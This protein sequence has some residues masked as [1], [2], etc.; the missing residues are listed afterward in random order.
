[1]TDGIVDPASPAAA[2]IESI[3]H[4]VAAIRTALGLGEDEERRVHAAGRYLAGYVDGWVDAF[5]TRLLGNPTAMLLL[6]DDARVIRLKRSLTAWFHELFSLPYDEHYGRARQAIGTAHV[7]INMPVYLMVTAMGGIRRDV[8]RSIA[9]AYAH[10]PAESEAVGRAVSLVLDLELAL[11]L[12]AFRREERALSRRQD[13]AVYAERAARRFSHLLIDRIN[14][15]ICYAELADR[16]DDRRAERLQKLKDVLQS[17]ARFDHRTQIQA[18][19]DGPPARRVRFA[20]LCAHALDNVRLGF[21]TSAS[22]S[23]DPPD[24]EADVY[25][26]PLELAVEE[27]AQNAALHAPGSHIE[28]AVSA[29]EEDVIAIAVTDQGPGWNEGVEEIKDI[30]SRGTG[31]GLSFCEIV[32]ELHDGSIDLFR[33]EEGGAGVRLTLQGARPDEV[34]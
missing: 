27:L 34:A 7:A 15:A 18:G 4:G 10:D 29:P 31:L 20:D 2:R 9:E 17:L 33:V 28:I 32:A 24:L 3:P 26:E 25:V 13:R 30:Y 1:M 14:A 12:Q 6:S 16:D 22:V 23:V 21:H 19:P 8:R 5:Y 11:M